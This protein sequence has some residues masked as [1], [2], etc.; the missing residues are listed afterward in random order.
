[1]KPKWHVV[2]LPINLLNFCKI[3]I[4]RNKEIEITGCEVTQIR[5]N[6]S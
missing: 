2:N 6:R 5:I 4:Y 1:M 3:A